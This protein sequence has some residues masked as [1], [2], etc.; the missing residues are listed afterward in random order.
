MLEKIEKNKRQI[1]NYT[2]QSAVLLFVGIYFIKQINPIINAA[3]FSHPTTDDYWMSSYV[4]VVWERT[5]SVFSAIAASFEYSVGMYKNWDGNFLSMFLTCLSPLAFNENYYFIVFYVM[6]ISLCAGIGL[7]AYSLLH[8]RWHIPLI[9]CISICLLFII[10]FL[11]YLPNS[12]E[13]LYWWPGV[14]NYTL[15][16][17]F[18]LFA[19]GLFVLYWNKNKIVWLILASISFFLVGLGNPLTGLVNVCLLAYELLYRFY[20]KRS[21]KTLFW[22]PFLCALIGLLIVVLAP[23]SSVRVPEV[24]MNFFEIVLS[25]FK[26]GTIMMRAIT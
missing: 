24:N 2:I 9:N 13:G 4:H 18:L 10:F 17:G 12:G 21:F 20:E 8:K 14:A 15:F 19:Q 16:F 7:I 26:N 3:K 6:L 1:I 22:I 23:A 25:S 5:H 11:N